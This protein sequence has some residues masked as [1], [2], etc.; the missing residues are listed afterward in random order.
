M[1]LDAIR[2]EL[3]V[4][5]HIAYL[6]AGTFGPLPRCCAVAMRDEEA[7]E[8][9]NGRSGAAYWERTN[10]LRQRARE[11]FGALIGSPADHI[12]LTRSTTEGCAIAVESLGLGPGDE[13]VTTDA[14]HFGLLGPL[15]AS[16]A[17]LAVAEV[18]ARP[19]ADALE[20]IESKIG[21]RTR[22][23]ALSHL[24]WVTGHLL[25]V[26]ELC[27]RDI[28]VLVD[29]AQAAGSIAVDAAGIGCDFYTISGQKWPLGPDATG[30]LYV[31]PRVLESLRVPLPSHFGTTSREA[32]GSF[33]PAPGARRFEP[34]AIPAP[35]LAGLCESLA[36]A[37]GL[38]PARF[39]KALAM[40]RHCGDALSRRV[41][42]VTEPGHATLVSFRPRGEAAAVVQQLAERGVVVRDLP[43][44]GWVRASIGFWTSEEDI[45]RLASGV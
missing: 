31:A 14:E 22:L 17:R 33:V 15:A 4:L 12:A 6:N 38:G 44:L 37:S 30:A 5:S 24:S 1:D 36:F 13:I 34:G 25:P 16:G 43:G 19:A 41:D 29:G 32:D 10:E 28:P 8:L 21:P 39:E 3:P 11:G 7:R 2:S 45:D 9:A 27:G 35:I 42:V 40:A 23:I 26:A 20:A 18:V